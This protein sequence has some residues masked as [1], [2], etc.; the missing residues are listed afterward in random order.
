MRKLS[1]LVSQFDAMDVDGTNLYPSLTSDQQKILNSVMSEYST[2]V[3]YAVLDAKSGSGKTTT[4]R[5]IVKEAQAKGLWIEV[6]ATT[7]KASS[8]LGGKTIHSFL[9]LKMTQ[10]DDA[11]N[12]DDALSLKSGDAIVDSPDI[13]IIDESS[14]IGMDLFRE[15]TKHR[16]KYVLFVLDSNQLPPVKAVKVEW[17]EVAHS[18]H[19]LTKTLRASDPHM[20]KLFE[21]FKDFKDGKRD[22]L[23]LHDY[24]NGR[25]IVSIDFN[26]CDFIPKNSD[27]CSVS[28]RNKLVEFMANKITIKGHNKYN[29]NAAVNITKMVATDKTD[30]NG[31]PKR[32]FVNETVFY[33]GEDVQIDLLINETKAMQKNGHCMYKNWKLSIGKAGNGITISDSKGELTDDTYYVKFPVDEVLEHCTLAIIEDKYFILIWD[34]GADEYKEMLDGL[35][36]KLHPLLAIHKEFKKH[37]TGKLNIVDCSNILREIAAKSIDSEEF[38]FNY[39]KHSISM[40]RK[41]AWS[42]FLSAKSVVTA[43]FTTSR[44]ITKAQGISVPC[45]VLTNN[46]FYGAST[47]AQYVAVTRGKHGIILI[48]N[49]PNILQG[50]EDD[51]TENYYN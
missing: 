16:F 15:I 17:H 44:T 3:K 28:Y 6:T 39:N 47:S 48:D 9:G 1:E 40:D 50:T 21:D 37:T 13:L 32:E 14:M 34:S 11:T 31:Y 41:Q 23:N 20:V 12:R 27:S 46:S 25:N 33:N 10:N 29:L 8:A 35:F 2:N 24:V 19:F 43:R 51:E 5:A 45:V 22:Q 4:I 36:A 42:N 30:Y 18:M 38:A 49:V 7:G 26:E